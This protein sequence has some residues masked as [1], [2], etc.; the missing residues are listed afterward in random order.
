MDKGGK[1]MD[2]QD[3]KQK[4]APGV[5]PGARKISIKLTL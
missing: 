4:K 1:C 5:F 2:Y 3:N